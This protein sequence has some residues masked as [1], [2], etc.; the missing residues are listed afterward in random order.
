MSDHVLE[1][2]TELEPA[3]TFTV[4]GEE[5]ELLGFEHLTPEQEAKAT[6]AFTR[7]QQAS[8]RLDRSSTD[9]EAEQRA[10]DVRKRRLDCIALLTTMPRE[11]AEKLPPS[12]QIKLFK[13]VNDEAGADAD[14]DD[15]VVD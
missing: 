1:L 13:A 10:K 2:T 9:K 6:G 3:A 11:V 14:E 5:Y 4:D 15:T 12:A 8:I 7:F